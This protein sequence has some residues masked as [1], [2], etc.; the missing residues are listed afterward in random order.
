MASYNSSD[1]TDMIRSK[2][3]FLGTYCPPSSSCGGGGGG[4]GET[5]PTGP[6]G[7]S[8]NTVLNGV[9][10]P[11]ASTGSNGD[12]YLDTSDYVMYGPKYPT[13][14]STWPDMSNSLRLNGN[15]VG[16]STTLPSTNVVSISLIPYITMSTVQFGAYD[17]TNNLPTL[18]ISN[19]T[20]NTSAV[21]TLDLSTKYS[22]AYGSNYNLVYTC[23]PGNT[24]MDVRFQ[25]NSTSTQIV[26]TNN[27]WYVSESLV[28]PTGATGATGLISAVGVNYGNFLYWNG[29]KWVTGDATIIMGQNAGQTNQR[30]ASI[31]IGTNAGQTNQATNG[32]GAALAFGANAGQSNQG[33]FG[34]AIG[35]N[36][37]GEN[38][39]QGASAIGGYAGWHSQGNNALAVGPSAGQ[40]NQGELTTAIG[41]GAGNS[42]QGRFSVCIGCGAG[43]NPVNTQAAA[44]NS[45][46]LNAQGSPPA[47]IVDLR[48]ATSGFFVSPIRNVQ[49]T[50]YLTY[51]TGTS[52]ITYHITGA[53][54]IRLKTDVADTTLGLNFITQLRPVEFKWKDR[55]KNELNYDGT[56]VIGNNPGMRVHQGLI[57]QEV[58]EV[59]DN[60]GVDSAIFMCVDDIPSG[61]VKGQKF[62]DNGH[63]TIDVDVPLPNGANGVQSLRYEEL[64][65]PSIKAIQELYAIVQTQAAQIKTLQ[66]Q[67]SALVNNTSNGN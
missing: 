15:V 47:T 66:D 54:D 55:K 64:I 21:I 4:N 24:L 44:P 28:G 42:T 40:E 46:I 52:E 20:A 53:S 36:A 9:G 38:Q 1:V 45:I 63:P 14:Y 43:R 61:S 5:G 31:A 7:P 12:F 51:D 2:R 67:V 62:D 22:V 13:Y 19:L 17:N 11:D 35:T 32:G 27:P 16:L 18:V 29:S 60:I 37:G 41:Y 65:S 34:L 39:G 57:A 59:L 26:W 23:S 30:A 6:T 8:G 33:S 10:P 49:G 56:P 48:S 50:Y 25:S 3:V 58:K